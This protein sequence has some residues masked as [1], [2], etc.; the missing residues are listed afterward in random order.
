MSKFTKPSNILALAFALV[1]G[2]VLF[3]YSVP[4]WLGVALFLTIAVSFYHLCSESD[5]CYQ[6]PLISSSASSARRSLV[7]MSSA[8]LLQT[9]GFGLALCCSR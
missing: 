8:L 6:F 4:G 9:K 5:T 3:F 2:V 7:M 1:A